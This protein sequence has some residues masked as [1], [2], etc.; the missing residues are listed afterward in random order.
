MADIPGDVHDHVIAQ[1][2]SK[3]WGELEVLEHA[4]YLLFPDVLLRRQ[5]DGSFKQEPVML[6]VPREPDMRK[7][8]VEAR[9]IFKKEGL[10]EKLDR[11]MFSNLESFCILAE[12]C[13]NVSPPHEPWVPDA[14]DLEKNYDKASLM[15]LWE[16]LER[17][18]DV[19][20]PA[21]EKISPQ[22]MLVL[23]AAIA[24]ERNIGPLA[25][26][27]SAAQTSFVVTMV[28]LLLS[29]SESKS[30]SELSE[31]LTQGLSALTE[32]AA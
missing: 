18:N 13:R 5:R 29:L 20:N 10:D 16:K 21:P 32:S 4:G 28:D 15:Q 17:L 1:L 9:A 11:V 24:K 23:L 12:A 22:E 2:L 31:H 3:D 19:V 25:V 6:R 26:Y 14:R 8:R 7:A 30:S 27:G